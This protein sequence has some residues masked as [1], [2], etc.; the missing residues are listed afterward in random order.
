MKRAVGLCVVLAC[1]PGLAQSAPESRLDS[2]SFGIGYGTQGLL[3]TTMRTGPTWGYFGGFSAMPDTSSPDTTEPGNGTPRWVQ[4][5]SDRG[6]AHLGLA[7]RLDSRWVVGV[8]VGYSHTAYRYTYNPG[9]SA[10]PTFTLPP[11]PGSLSDNRFGLVAMA[12]VRLG[13]RWGVEVVGGVIGV[14]GAVTFR[15]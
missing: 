8:G 13:P 4:H 11:G 7:Y 15:F 9:A 14:G 2:A 3:F 6:E 12:D 5:E 10:V 1:L